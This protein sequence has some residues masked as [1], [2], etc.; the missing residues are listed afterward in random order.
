M[1]TMR[2]SRL[3]S[4][5]APFGRRASDGFTGSSVSHCGGPAVR[6]ILSFQVPA[7]RRAFETT[8]WFQQGLLPW[9][10]AYECLVAATHRTTWADSLFDAVYHTGTLTLSFTLVAVR[11]PLAV[12]YLLQS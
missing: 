1:E 9:I 5:G 4:S 11:E 3:I 10:K 7:R 8:W 6:P 12:C 2:E